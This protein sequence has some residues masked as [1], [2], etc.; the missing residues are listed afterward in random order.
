MVLSEPLKEE[1]LKLLKKQK[2]ADLISVYL[3]FLEKSFNINPVLFVRNK[4]IYENREVLIQ[5]LEQ[6]G[7]L[8]KISEVTIP[9]EK[10]SVDEKTTKIYICPSTGKV[11]GN[12]THPNPQDA[13]YDWISS[14][15][16]LTEEGSLK[17]KS[18]FISEDPEVIKNYIS[19]IK[20]PIKKTLFSSAVTGKLFN[21]KE[22]VIQDCV[23]NQ[24]KAITLPE[25]INQNQYA[26]D[27]PFLAFI[28]EQLEESKISSFV[29]MI[30]KIDLFAPYIGAWTEESNDE[31]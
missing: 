25:A 9:S 12:N 14:H 3:F 21:S 4:I 20:E 22:A 13:I 5:K 23:K 31:S 2:Q 6:A 24:I 26:I 11:F 28:K 15:T 8:W 29:D 27:E 10:P 16:G 18:F 17:T 30:S 7:K 1:I 19:K